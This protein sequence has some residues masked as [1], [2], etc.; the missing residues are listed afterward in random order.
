MFVGWYHSHP[1]SS[2]WL[3]GLDCDT[4][5]MFQNVFKTFFALVVDPYKTLS[6]RKVE[7]GCF[8]NYIHEK[9]DNQN[10]YFENIPINKAEVRLFNLN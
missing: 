2:C 4:H 8:R 7:I 3:S 1:G 10:D 5:N 9:K 6:N